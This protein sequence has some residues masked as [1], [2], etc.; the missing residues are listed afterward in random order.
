MVEK[1]V[2][3][4]KKRKS[5]KEK[6]ILNAKER[7]EYLGKEAE[8]RD[9]CD[10]YGIYGYSINSDFSIDADSVHINRKNLTSFPLKFGRI[11]GNFS[12]EDNHLS[13]LEGSPYYVGGSFMVSYNNITSL[14]GCPEF[15]GG[16]FCFAKNKVF[17]LDGCTRKIGDQ[18]FSA[19]NPIWEIFQ[20]FYGIQK[21]I[22]FEHFYSM[23]R[24]IF[25]A[26]D[27]YNPVYEKN[28]K[29]YIYD[30][31]LRELYL[32]VTDKKYVGEFPEFKNYTIDKT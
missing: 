10:G 23:E 9:I 19:E 5:E 21:N 32:D 29:W 11:R 18:I 1:F 31:R 24:K 22:K 17:T 6:Q 13:T 12:A 25:E 26:W 30:Y 14:K 27:L 2:E 4:L 20:H 3:Y 8:M 7:K 28:G 16:S 15:V